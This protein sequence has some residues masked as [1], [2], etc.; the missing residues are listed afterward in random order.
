MDLALGGPASGR[1]TSA[2]AAGAVAFARHPGRRAGAKGHLLLA[3][4]GPTR[5]LVGAGALQP[6]TRKEL[7]TFLQLGTVARVPG[8]CH[9][10]QIL[11]LDP[12]TACS[13]CTHLCT[14]LSL[15]SYCSMSETCSC[16][17]PTR[18]MAQGIIS[19]TKSTWLGA[20]EGPAGCSVAGAVVGSP[21][22][23]GVGKGLAGCS[24]M[25]TAVGNPAGAV[26]AEGAGRC[27]EAGGA[28]GAVPGAAAGSAAGAAAP[29]LQAATASA[30]AVATA[31]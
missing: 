13:P 25:G 22:G 9:E 4:E 11:D 10:E 15:A 6:A 17:Q 29:H 27:S 30:R 19:Y 2:A 26:A 18:S 16:P 12:L 1:G 5:R 21:T 20:S 8:A 14:R 28:P 31:G 24:A 3:R 7:A 23:V